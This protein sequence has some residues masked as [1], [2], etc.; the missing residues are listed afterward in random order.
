MATPSLSVPK[1]EI[2]IRESPLRHFWKAEIPANGEC[3]ISSLYFLL[4]AES[5]EVNPER[6]KEALL[7]LVDRLSNEQKEVFAERLKIAFTQTLDEN[8]VF[9][10]NE[11][12]THLFCQMLSVDTQRDLNWVRDA[13]AVC[14]DKAA[15]WWTTDASD[16][17]PVI[18]LPLTAQVTGKNVYIMQCLAQFDPETMSG[19]K[20][21]TSLLCYSKQGGEQLIDGTG[22]KVAIESIDQNDLVLER[23]NN[24]GCEHYDAHICAERYERKHVTQTPGIDALLDAAAYL[25]LSE[26]NPNN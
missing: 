10:I 14:I 19:S 15:A 21:A 18:F 25:A 16:L 11:A 6:R 4:T 13:V 3:F 5:G 7:D 26:D 23:L 8:V 12:F 17:L 22:L 9:S 20:E 2:V 1:P 24:R